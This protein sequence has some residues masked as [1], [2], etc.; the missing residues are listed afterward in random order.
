MVEFRTH[1]RH[2]AKSNTLPGIPPTSSSAPKASAS[3]RRVNA[4]MNSLSTLRRSLSKQATDLRSGLPSVTP[5]T[6]SPT[7][8]SSPEDAAAAEQRAIRQDGVDTDDELRRYEQ[9]GRIS[10][11]QIEDENFDLVLWWQVRLFLLYRGFNLTSASSGT[12]ATVPIPLPRRP[13][14]PSRASVGCPV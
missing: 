5:T 1:D 11:E 10:E 6:S 14:H 8:E 13:R 4:S 3:I 7:H 12:C 9:Q 2:A